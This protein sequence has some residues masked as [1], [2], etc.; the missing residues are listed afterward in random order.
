METN[1][2]KFN[3]KKSSNSLEDELID[4]EEEFREDPEGVEFE[5]GEEE[6]SS[7][8]CGEEL[9]WLFCGNCLIGCY[10]NQGYNGG[11]G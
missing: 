3:R 5:D 2:S 6:F 8:G 9:L 10:R 7:G 4:E 11:E 1:G